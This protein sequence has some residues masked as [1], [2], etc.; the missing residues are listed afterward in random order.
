MILEIQK[1]KYYSLVIHVEYEMN[2]IRIFSI[3][4]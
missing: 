2:S 4:K 1:F 3:H